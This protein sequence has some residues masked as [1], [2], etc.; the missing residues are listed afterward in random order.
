M[1]RRAKPRKATPR[2]V[3]PRKAAPRRSAAPVSQPDVTTAEQDAQAGLSEQ[4]RRQ[5]AEEEARF[6]A[7]KPADP[8]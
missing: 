8:N 1:V 4:E 2:Q 3:T 6:R 5:L 7:A